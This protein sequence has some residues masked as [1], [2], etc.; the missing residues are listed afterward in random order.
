M[1][2]SGNG[3]SPKGRTTY[4]NIGTAEGI[5]HIS[6]RRSGAEV[7][8]VVSPAAAWSSS[9]IRAISCIRRFISRPALPIQQHGDYK[10]RWAD[11][12][13]ELGRGTDRSARWQKRRRLRKSTVDSREIFL[14]WQ[15]IRQHC[16]SGDLS[17]LPCHNRYVDLDQGRAPDW[18][19]SSQQRSAWAVASIF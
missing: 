12:L 9:R 6:S 17:A 7:F 11:P 1:T 2:R 10:E 13:C 15:I 4:A 8:W 19:A 3:P 14:N 5:A 16:A 18:P